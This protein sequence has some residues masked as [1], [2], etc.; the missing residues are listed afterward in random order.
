[1]WLSS[2]EALYRI[3]RTPSENS[4]GVWCYNNVAMDHFR[5]PAAALRLQYFTAF[6]YNVSG[7]LYSEING[8]T[9]PYTGKHPQD[10]YNIWVNYIWLYPGKNPGETMPSLRMTLTRE[11]LDDYDYLALY[12][13]K[14]PGRKL[15]DFVNEVMPELQPTGDQKFPVVSQ[16]KLQEVRDRL[17]KLLE[18]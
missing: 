6:K 1:M 2:F 8:Y 15:P 9:K 12:R 5:H 14:F 4:K 11:G 7:Y 16:R 10:I 17:A 13:Q 3:R 18:Q